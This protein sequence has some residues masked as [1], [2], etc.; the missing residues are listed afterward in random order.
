MSS[1][2]DGGTGD[3]E[4]NILSAFSNNDYAPSFACGFEASANGRIVCYDGA[5]TTSVILIRTSLT[6]TNQDVPVITGST[7]GDLA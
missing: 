6:T 5:F 1:L 7:H 2:T 3:Y 4:I